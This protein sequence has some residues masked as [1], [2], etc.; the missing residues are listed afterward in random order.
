MANDTPWV[1]LGGR[2]GE[3]GY[4]TRCGEGLD[5]G[6]SQPIYLFVAMADAFT[7]HHS[8]CKDNGPVDVPPES[9]YNWFNGRDTGTSSLTIYSVFMHRASPHNRYDA[10]R[11]PNDFGRCYRLLHLMPAWRPRLA[12]VAARYPIWG[13][14]VD[15]WDELV[16]LYE[17]ELPSG[18]APRLY[19]L[20]QDL[21]TAGQV[22][23]R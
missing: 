15:R 16:A 18:K 23:G 4:C 21:Y 9:I 11:D 7:R 8:K 14:M 6:K 10:P 2:S 5:M 19:K 20:M 17:E 1:V 13:P 3:A 22:A 12:E